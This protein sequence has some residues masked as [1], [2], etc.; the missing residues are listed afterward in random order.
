MSCG[1][2]FRSFT[3]RHVETS[4]KNGTFAAVVMP[5]LNSLVVFRSYLQKKP[6]M[7]AS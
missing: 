4:E 2:N 5:L 3:A 6:R 7:P 1:S